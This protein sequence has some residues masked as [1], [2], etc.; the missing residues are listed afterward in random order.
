MT[1]HAESIMVTI[2]TS[3]AGDNGRTTAE[4]RRD[5]PPRHG[6]KRDDSK[7]RIG[8]TTNTSRTMRNTTATGNWLPISGVFSNTF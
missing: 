2:T 1:A 4:T 6:D 7:L 8:L 3:S 5:D